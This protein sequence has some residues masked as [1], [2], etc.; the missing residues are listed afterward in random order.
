[1]TR[2]KIS[3]HLLFTA[4]FAVFVYHFANNFILKARWFAPRIPLYTPIDVCHGSVNLIDNYPSNSIENVIKIVK[5]SDKIFNGVILGPPCDQISEQECLYRHTNQL[6]D[7]GDNICCFRQSLSTKKL[8]I[9]ESPN[10]KI[11]VQTISHQFAYRRSNKPFLGLNY[12]RL[13][14]EKTLMIVNIKFT[15]YLFI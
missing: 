12:L 1:M 9:I 14:W 13:V 7:P 15:F 10:P 11:N 3:W 5:I 8:A 6:S 4:F 2:C